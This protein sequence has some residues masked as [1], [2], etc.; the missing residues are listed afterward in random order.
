MNRVEDVIAE[1]GSK[2]DASQRWKL[3]KSNHSITD[4]LMILSDVVKVVNLQG[5][6]KSS[7]RQASELHFDF[8]VSYIGKYYLISPRY[9]KLNY[10]I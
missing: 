1:T 2:K 8:T 5:K 9:A 4:E 7:K 10:F 6:L 3:S